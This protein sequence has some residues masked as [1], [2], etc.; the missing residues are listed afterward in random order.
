MQDVVGIAQGKVKMRW[1]ERVARYTEDRIR[2]LD[3]SKHNKLLVKRRE[4]ENVVECRPSMRGKKIW[5]SQ[6]RARCVDSSYNS[7]TVVGKIRVEC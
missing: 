6:T 3:E 2:A 1:C 5:W 7:Q 4:A